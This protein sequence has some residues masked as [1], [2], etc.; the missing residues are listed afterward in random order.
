MNRVCLTL[1]PF[2][3]L[4]AS[5]NIFE[6]TFSPES[7]DDFDAVFAEAEAR[8]IMRDYEKASGLF[9]RAA[10]LQPASAKARYGRLKSEILFATDARPLITV[11]ETL[12]SDRNTNMQPP[13]H[14]LEEPQRT[15]LLGALDAACDDIAFILHPDADDSVNTNANAFLMDAGLIH[16]AF[17]VLSLA[18]NSHLALQGT[19]YF[20]ISPQFQAEQ[21]VNVPNG[22]KEAVETWLS[23]L[24][25]HLNKGREYIAGLRL[26]DPVI[27][28]DQ[29]SFWYLDSNITALRNSIN[30]LDVV[31]E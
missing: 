21:A 12:F 10:S 22:T 20:I 30:S 15:R 14:T 3:L 29:S 27:G 9:S 23:N 17:G 5:C 6:W 2:A 31:E 24:E 28:S 1:M 19:A 26:I 13:L 11:L 16:T 18:D 8:F 25:D 4:L 7:S